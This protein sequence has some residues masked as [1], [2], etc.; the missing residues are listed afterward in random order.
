MITPAHRRQHLAFCRHD[1]C[2][3]SAL[4]GC[5]GVFRRHDQRLRL[6]AGLP[7]RRLKDA[8]FHGPL[9]VPAW[10][11]GLVHKVHK[12]PYMAIFM[13][14]GI[15]LVLLLAL[16]PQGFL[17]GFGLTGTIA[18]YG[19]VVVYLG[20]CIVAPI[21][22]YKGGMMKA[23]HVIA[24][25][26]G[27]LLMGFVIYSSV[28]PLPGIPI[29]LFTAGLRHLHGHRV[30]LVR[31]PESQKPANSRLDCQ[32]HGRLVSRKASRRMRAASAVLIDFQTPPDYLRPIPD[33]GVAQR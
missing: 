33:G 18:T 7:Q 6:L 11:H 22:M 21:D 15:S 32:R 23:Q 5:R 25:V 26:I 16:M 19:F 24:G 4:G 17:N 28:F 10:V 12:T 14:A 9:P 13:S 30:H 3:A 31:H 29:Q 2:R 27:A 1:Q 20:V 8:V